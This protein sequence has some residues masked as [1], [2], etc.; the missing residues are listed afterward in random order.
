MGKV[1]E[2]G[3]GT[4]VLFIS[5]VLVAAISAGV[6]I[7][8]SGSLQETARTTGEDARTKISTNIKMVDITL[9]KDS[10]G[11]YRNLEMIMKLTPGSEAIKINNSLLTVSLQDTST[12]LQYRGVNGTSDND[13]ATGYRTY[14]TQEIGEIGVYKSQ[15]GA[16]AITTT[17]RT[18]PDVDYDYDG[19]ADT[20]KMCCQ[21][22]DGCEDSSYDD[23]YSGNESLEGWLEFHISSKGYYY[24]QVVDAGGTPIPLC[25]DTGIAAN[26]KTPIDKW[27]YVTIWGDVGAITT[28]PWQVVTFYQNETWLTEDL[29][30]DGNV[31]DYVQVNQTHAIFTWTNGDVDYVG[32][33]QNI[34]TPQTLSLDEGKIGYSTTTYK[35]KLTLSGTTSRDDYIDE[36]VTFTV[37]PVTSTGYFV[38]EYL[39]RSS[40][41][42]DGVMKPGDV[43]R[44]YG[45]LPRAIDDEER[46]L[47][48]LVPKRGVP[49][50]VETYTPSVMTESQVSL[51]P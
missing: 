22:A 35:G 31:S 43:V 13:P 4:L 20:V 7:Q 1:G 9:S 44:I 49:T 38:S 10:Y 48:N 12:T 26:N 3:I 15:F 32:L 19:V 29:D 6:L 33:G 21:G 30:D 37:D 46:I 45:Q 24:I 2:M 40:N 27:G 14:G 16:G 23:D 36:D 11:N 18:I 39:Q 42:I 25:L 28:I 41:S 47:V 50:R 34:S 51:Y 5:L 8:T 17:A